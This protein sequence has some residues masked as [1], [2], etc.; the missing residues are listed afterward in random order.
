MHVCVSVLGFFCVTNQRAVSAPRAPGGEAFTCLLN[1]LRAALQAAHQGATGTMST[2]REG[3]RCLTVCLFVC[4]SFS[5]PPL[6]SIIPSKRPSSFALHQA[7]LHRPRVPQTRYRD[8]NICSAF[9][10]RSF[11]TR[12]SEKPTESNGLFGTDCL[13]HPPDGLASYSII[14]NSSLWKVTAWQMV[15]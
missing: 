3:A 1:Q 11:C 5:P 6:C 13:R 7:I 9:S 12:R 10:Y 2:V 15:L 14:I 4:L 8:G